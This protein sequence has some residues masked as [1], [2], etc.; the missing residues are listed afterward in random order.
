M[1]PSFRTPDQTNT[2]LHELGIDLPSVGV[3]E[4][5]ATGQGSITF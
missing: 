1:I 3:E 2:A 5:K 4:V